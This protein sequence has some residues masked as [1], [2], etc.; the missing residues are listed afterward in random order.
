MLGMLQQNCNIYVAE[1]DR[2]FGI[3][4]HSEKNY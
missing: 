1:I 2:L 4:R 3:G